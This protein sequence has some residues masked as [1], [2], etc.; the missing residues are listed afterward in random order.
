MQVIFEV[1]QTCATSSGQ[2][3]NFEKSSVYF[4]NNT[5]REQ[6]DGIKMALGIR[7]V[8]QFE[9]YL[10][11][12]T[13]V[14]RSKYRTFSFLKDRVWK[15]IQGWKRQLLSRA[16]KEILIKAV[17]QSIPTYTM[18]VFQLPVKLC[19]ELNAMCARF[20][21]GQV[22]NERKIHWR[23]WDV[24]SQP[25]REGGMGFRDIRAFNLT[26]LAKQGWRLLQDKGSLLYG[27]FKARYFPRSSF[28]EA[29]DVS[30]SSYV[31]KS[32]IAA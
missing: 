2:C 7:E 20:W 14:G 9:S 16:G 8:V 24:L 11:L 27:C 31:W 25:K 5:G 17:A 32:L 18:G 6:R 22:G 19:N 26:M 4:S 29:A 15:K 1:L 23:S 10:G 13:L 30:N 21:W 12:P 3:I 28:L